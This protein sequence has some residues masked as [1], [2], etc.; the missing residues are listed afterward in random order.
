MIPVAGNVWQHVEGG[1]PAAAA[2]ASG[3]IMAKTTRLVNG[4][5][6]SLSPARSTLWH[7]HRLPVLKPAGREVLVEGLGGAVVGLRVV[8]PSPRSHAGLP[9]R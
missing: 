9:G 5:A 8:P 1:S 3:L 2:A 4:R 6:V 7:S